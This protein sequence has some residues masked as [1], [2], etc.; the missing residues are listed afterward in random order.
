MRKFVQNSLLLILLL[1]CVSIPNDPIEIAKKETIKKIEIG[2][3]TDIFWGMQPD[4]PLT[5]YTTYAIW[6][7][8]GGSGP[9]PEEWCREY[10]RSK[11]P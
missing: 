2:C 7:E 1:G 6:M 4:Y 8:M 5:D 10:A 11:V 3:L 9:S